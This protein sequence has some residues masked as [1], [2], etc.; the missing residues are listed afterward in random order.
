MAKIKIDKE[1]CIACG[2]CSVNLPE[3]IETDEE[4]KAQVRAEHIDK[5]ID[6]EELKQ[7]AKDTADLCAVGAITVED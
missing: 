2:I 1:K 7:R 3:L 4:G 5:E 6:D